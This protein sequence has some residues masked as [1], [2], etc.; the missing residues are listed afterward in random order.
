V[1]IATVYVEADGGLEKLMDEVIRIDV[2][3]GKLRLTDLLGKEK[4]VQGKL[5]SIDFWEEHSVIVEPSR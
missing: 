3:N 5:R 1:C 4:Y 2:E